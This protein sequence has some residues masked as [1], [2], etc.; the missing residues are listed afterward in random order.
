MSVSCL[1]VGSQQRVE[2]ISDE[3]IFTKFMLWRLLVFVQNIYLRLES[4]AW[5]TPNNFF[6]PAKQLEWK[7]PLS[8]FRDIFA[9]TKYRLSAC[10]WSDICCQLR[11]IFGSWMELIVFTWKVVGVIRSSNSGPIHPFHPPSFQGKFIWYTYVYWH[12]SQLNYNFHG[13]LRAH[14]GTK[15]WS[16]CR[17]NSWTR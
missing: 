5:C 3:K 7:Q 6:E 13:A 8:P 15:Y 12:L 4:S 11:R 16:A 1:L 10:V 17:V 2:S 14:N 9:S